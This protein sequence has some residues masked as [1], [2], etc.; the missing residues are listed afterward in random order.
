MLQCLHIRGIG[1]G[2]RDATSA[3]HQHIMPSV[4]P[5]LISSSHCHQS[6]LSEAQPSYHHTI[7]ASMS[8]PMTVMLEWMSVMRRMALAVMGKPIATA[9]RSE[10]SMSVDKSVSFS[11]L[12]E[13]VRSCDLNHDPDVSLAISARH[14]HAMPSVELLFNAIITLPLVDGHWSA[15]HPMMT[16]T[17][18]SQP[19]PH[20]K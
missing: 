12:V 15:A 4:K 5:C 11:V 19:R 18:Y 1:L 6:M 2:V 13:S 20:C 14:Q 7:A 3:R 17:C 8:L 9:S 16:T 10:M